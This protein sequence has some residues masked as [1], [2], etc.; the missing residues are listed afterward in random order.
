[1][2]GRVLT[3]KNPS[4]L[5]PGDLLLLD[6][7]RGTVAVEVASVEVITDLTQR[8]YSEAVLVTFVDDTLP[9]VFSSL[10]KHPLRVVVSSV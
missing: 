8:D 4:Q 2:S 10:G 6:Q 7:L 5:R 1:M 9:Y 3:S